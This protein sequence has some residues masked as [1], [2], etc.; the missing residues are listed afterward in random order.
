MVSVCNLRM[1][2]R[3]L[4]AL[5]GGFAVATVC[6]AE[7]HVSLNGIFGKRAVLVVDGAD[8]QIVTEGGQTRE[9][10]RLVS[11]RDGAAVV[12]V[13]G[14]RQQLRV[15]DGPIRT[16]PAA[17]A[18]VGAGQEVRILS[19]ARGHFS[20]R[21][22]I[23]D[24][25]MQFLVDTGATLVS[26]GV[27]DARRAGINYLSGAPSTSMTANGPVRVWLVRLDRVQVGSLVLRNVDAAV[28]EAPLPFVLLGSSFL[29]RVAMQR[30]GDT[31]ILRR[32]F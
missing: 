19:D 4:A 30:E 14:R 11:I 25:A 16:A 21:G 17:D 27:A 26:L 29:Q 15:G 22:A 8:P 7:M 9:G 2:L 3:G 31:L 12:E 28:H 1:L 20:T 10:V 6:A 24:A 13:D 23:N 5:A 18:M 32:R